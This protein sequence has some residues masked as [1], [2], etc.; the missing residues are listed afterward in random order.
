MIFGLT[1]T[2]CSKEEAVLPMQQADISAT[3]EDAN[4]DIQAR[5][6]RGALALDEKTMKEK[7]PV[8]E[9]TK[10]KVY[11]FDNRHQTVFGTTGADQ[12]K[13]IREID[14]ERKISI[15]EGQHMTSYKE[16]KAVLLDRKEIL[17]QD[18]TIDSFDDKM[19][20]KISIHNELDFTP[21]R[22][23]F[24]ETGDRED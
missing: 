23:E 13:N 7:E 16:G 10:D 8:R 18:R 2:G 4:E 15:H 12:D 9:L 24:K 11:L 19:K 14:A 22:S 3:R 21:A 1:F 20:E 6:V 5:S 17:G